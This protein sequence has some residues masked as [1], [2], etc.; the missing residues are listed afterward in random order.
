MPNRIILKN[1]ALQGFRAFLRPQTF[2]FGTAGNSIAVFAPN[3]RGKSSLV[4]GLE[5]FLSADATLAR[6]G[7]NRT[8]NQAGRDALSH[9]MAADKGVVSQVS[10]TFHD[11]TSEFADTRPVVSKDYAMPPS[12]ARVVASLRV[13]ML[14]RGYELRRFVEDQTAEDRYEEIA[15]WFSLSRLVNTQSSIKDARSAMKKKIADTSTLT[16]RTKDLIR[17]TGGGLRAWDESEVLRWFNE[18]YLNPLDSKLR[19]S[20][21]A[22]ADSAVPIIRARKEEEERR[23]GL[24]TLRDSIAQIKSVYTEKQP[25]IGSGAVITLEIAYRN[26]SDARGKMESEKA[27]AEKAVFKDLWESA[28]K[29]FDDNAIQFTACPVCSAELKNTP[30]GNR[31]AIGKELTV[32]LANLKDYRDAVQALENAKKTALSEWSALKVS[33]EK[34][35]ALLTA[36]GCSA[37]AKIVAAYSSQIAEMVKTKS[38]PDSI[39][40]K[41]A[42]LSVLPVVQERHDAIVKAQ[43]K[44]T[45]GKALS[46]YAEL[47]IV[48]EALAA[49]TAKKDQLEKLYKSL[50]TVGAAIDASIRGYVESIISALRAD[51]NKFY[52][53]F[54]DGSEACPTVRLELPPLEEVNQ[55][56]LS[57]VIDFG[58][59]TCVPPSGY[60]SDS[61]VHTLAL[62]LRLAAMKRLNNAVP[63]VVLDDIVTSYDADH[64]RYV[65]AAIAE[66]LKDFQVLIVTHDERFF[67][68]L[69]DVLPQASW[70]FRRIT[71]LEPEFGPRFADHKT[72]EQDIE[73]TWNQ[74]KKA[75]NDIRQAEEEWLHRICL[76]FGVDARMKDFGMS[77][78]RSEC[79]QA[80]A[81]FLKA[82]NI[83]VPQVTGVA[84]PFLVS[85]SR[86]TVENFGSHFQSSAYSL[87]SIGDERKRWSE[88]KQFR[89]MFKCPS[90]GRDR[91]ERPLTLKLPVCRHCQTP[92][93]FARQQ[94]SP[95]S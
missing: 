76:E 27:K 21:L 11:G 44:N 17:I 26:L 42:L 3:A 81:S 80:L 33:V 72:T 60:L 67:A 61:Q 51:T 7:K 14:I 63:I 53:A 86:G 34:L 6:L 75:S 24:D 41:T 94:S 9:V 5:F 10:L 8:D 68:H 16:E 70:A 28:S 29:V 46:I 18:N 77:Y 1:L 55:R 4:D 31:E 32:R 22:D 13:P 82:K 85:L 40:I 87:P 64:R 39:D 20:G 65:A 38:V 37:E 19:L 71:I 35:Q 83:S 30:A 78:E 66:H 89:E 54:Q 49:A 57:L 47:V 58:C 56:R 23:V 92:F 2:E 59:R 93:S 62:S 45:Y 36:A 43:G 50:A 95:G 73:D 52:Q 91:F 88:F 90:C 12:A 25:G 48:K 69:K 84:N 79:A 74:G 15:R